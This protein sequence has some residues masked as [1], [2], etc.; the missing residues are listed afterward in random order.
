MA[1]TVKADHIGKLKDDLIRQIDHIRLVIKEKANKVPEHVLIGDAIVAAEWVR[2]AE[3]GY[4]CPY[5]KIA[6]KRKTV[7]QLEEILQG[8]RD[9][10][11]SLE[12]PPD[13][14]TPQVQPSTNFDLFA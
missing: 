11:K 6:N 12:A 14:P 5:A 2:R 13:R 8:E 7:E 3:Q 9:L 4:F 1:R 10:M